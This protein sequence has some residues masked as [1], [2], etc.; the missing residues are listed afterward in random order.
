MP[1]RISSWWSAAAFAF[2][3]AAP[4]CSGDR[5]PPLHPVRGTLIV[6]GQLAAKAVVVLRPA[7]PGPWKGPIPHGEVGPDGAFR[8]GTYAADDG[9]PAGEYT[10]TFTWPEVRTDPETHDVVSE[11]RLM[12][13]YAEAAKSPWKVTVK[14]GDNDLGPFALE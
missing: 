8:I 7:S 5:R 6:G 12:G 11:D 10:V 3:L 4:A 1:D 2:A 14:P 13:R 9:A